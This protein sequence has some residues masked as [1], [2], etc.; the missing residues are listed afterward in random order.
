MGY[1]VGYVPSIAPT[2]GNDVFS[3]DGNVGTNAFVTELMFTGE[4]TSTLAMRTAFTRVTTRG[5]TIATGPVQ[6]SDAPSFAAN[7]CS[8]GTGWTNQPIVT[9][10]ALFGPSW[11]VHGG[12][13]YWHAAPGEEIALVGPMGLSARA[14]V[15]TG[16]STYQVKWREY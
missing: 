4:T 9:A 15:G 14:A 16:L 7:V 10:G 11:N 3:F 6:K 12:I 13:A 8:F 1:F 2:V 5:T